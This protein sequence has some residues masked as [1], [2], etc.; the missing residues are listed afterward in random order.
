MQMSQ[1]WTLTESEIYEALAE[2]IAS[3]KSFWLFTFPEVDIIST[4]RIEQVLI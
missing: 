3:K 1:N 2:P 4:T